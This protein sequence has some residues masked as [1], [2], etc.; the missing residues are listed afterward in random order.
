MHANTF[1]KAKQN[2]KVHKNWQQIRYSEEPNF[3]QSYAFPSKTAVVVKIPIP[4]AEAYPCVGSFSDTAINK[5]ISDF[6]KL[7]KKFE[8]L[9][10][11]KE[12][13]F[14]TEKYKL[15]NL[16]VSHIKKKHFIVVVLSP[17]RAET[18]EIRALLKSEL[19][20]NVLIC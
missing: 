13:A 7:S 3:E 19:P 17:K 10:K 9:N 1:G 20:E 8:I 5:Y 12:I 16:Y 14:A 18:E 15:I 6:P 4:T 11:I 2:E